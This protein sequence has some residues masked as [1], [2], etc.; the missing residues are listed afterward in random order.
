[1]ASV[2][3]VAAR[4]TFVTTRSR[5]D[6]GSRIGAVNT[7]GYGLALRRGAHTG[8]SRSLLAHKRTGPRPV[9]CVLTVEETT[10]ANRI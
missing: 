4:G 8:A 5:G 2:T 10:K 3:N 9:K 1:M 6:P 7:A